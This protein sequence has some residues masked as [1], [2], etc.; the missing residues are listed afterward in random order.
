MVE[1]DLASNK[2]KRAGTTCKGLVISIEAIDP[3]SAQWPYVNVL[4]T[5]FGL[6]Q[7]VRLIC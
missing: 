6:Q 1:K 5:L 3:F 7:Q 4:N 2:R